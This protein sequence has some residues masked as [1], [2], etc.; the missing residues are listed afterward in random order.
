MKL[1]GQVSSKRVTK[2]N[3][4]KKETSRKEVTNVIGPYTLNEVHA[5]VGTEVGATL[6][7]NYQSASIK[8]FVTIPVEPN[9]KAVKAGLDYCFDLANQRLS[10]EVEG[11]R[12]ALEGK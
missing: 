12:E 7:H 10:E 11:A 1:T 9:D 2:D 6:T 4:A 3:V 5:K 8:V